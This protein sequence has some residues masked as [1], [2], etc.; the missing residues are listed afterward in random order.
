M[1]IYILNDCYFQ[2]AKREELQAPLEVRGGASCLLQTAVHP[3]DRG[4]QPGRP[5]EEPDAEGGTLQDGVEV[6]IQVWQVRVGI[7]TKGFR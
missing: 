2:I 6:S 4:G 3:G 1:S 5:H 7:F